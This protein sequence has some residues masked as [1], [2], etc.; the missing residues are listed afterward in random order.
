MWLWVALTLLLMED[1]AADLIARARVGDMAAQWEAARLSRKGQLGQLSPKLAAA[2]YKKALARRVPGACLEEAH[3][4]MEKNEKCEEWLR[5]AASG[6]V[7]EGQY[8]LGRMILNTIAAEDEPHRFEG[9]AWVA[10]AAKAG[11]GPALR[12]W[13]MLA[14][15]LPLEDLE[16]VEQITKKLL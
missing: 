7:A 2:W 3:L 10:L 5:C 11:Y 8:L 1:S 14:V 16:R 4:K 15:E 13:E 12:R 9:L 6:R